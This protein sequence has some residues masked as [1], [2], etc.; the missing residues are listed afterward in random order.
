[1]DRTLSLTTLSRQGA[2][3]GQLVTEL[4]AALQALAQP[5]H[6]QTSAAAPDAAEPLHGLDALQ[7]CLAIEAEMFCKRLHIFLEESHT[8]TRERG[9]TQAESGFWWK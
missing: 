8:S 2:Y 7:K 5:L 3:L 6:E 1:M 4:N 9:K